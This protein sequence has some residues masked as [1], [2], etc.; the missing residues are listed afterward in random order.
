M[1]THGL[2]SSAVSMDLLANYLCGKGL[3]VLCP[4]LPGHL[5]GASSRQVSGFSDVC[6]AIRECAE[7]AR[8]LWSMPL[9]LAGHSL[10]GAASLCVTADLP[11]VTGAVGIAIGIDAGRGFD[12]PIGQSMRASRSGYLAG[13][14][15]EL[16]LAEVRESMHDF[17]GIG[18]RP[19][20]LVAAKGDVIMSADEINELATQCQ[21]VAT[22]VEVNATH[23]AAPDACKALLHR[24]FLSLF[25]TV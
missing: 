15:P 18:D 10:G 2:T 20:L 21:P 25:T 14:T 1:L 3:P 13:C 19:L 5:L 9:V 24:Y 23:L 12:G 22:V 16:M 8:Q 6:L 17:R 7:Y 11:W 4:D